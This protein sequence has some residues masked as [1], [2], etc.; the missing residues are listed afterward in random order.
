MIGLSKS[1]DQVFDIGL[2]DQM[3]ESQLDHIGKST[4]IQNVDLGQGSRCRGHGDANHGS[5]P[6]HAIRHTAATSVGRYR[7]PR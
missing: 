1:L 6:E 7:V 4:G 2:L 5:P 3:I